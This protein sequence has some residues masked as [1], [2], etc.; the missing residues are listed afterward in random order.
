MERGS[1]FFGAVLGIAHSQGHLIAF[2]QCSWMHELPLLLKRSVLTIYV[3]ESLIGSQ[4]GG[5]QHKRACV[6]IAEWGNLHVITV[7]YENRNSEYLLQS[8][9]NVF[10]IRVE[11]AGFFNF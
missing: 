8:L 3:Q 1:I 5:G 9:F 7:I 11:P 4:F 10:R 6:K 2:A